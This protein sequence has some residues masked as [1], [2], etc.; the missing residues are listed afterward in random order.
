MK[1]LHLAFFIILC[2]LACIVSTSANDDAE[3]NT[4]IIF[5]VNKDFKP[6]SKSKAKMLFKG[7][8]KRLNNEKFE[9]A[10]WDESSSIRKAFYEAVLG[11]SIP[12]MNGYWASR[13]FS[14]KGKP[15]TEI[16]NSTSA[17]VNEWLASTPNG[18]AYSRLN[19]APTNANILFMIKLD[20][21]L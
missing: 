17:L 7:K 13:V 6:I 5:S 1:N 8:V 18:I 2:Y 11:K 14:G 20:E 3:N 16:K 4:L 9:L 10:D 19:D 15:P 21:K 12:E